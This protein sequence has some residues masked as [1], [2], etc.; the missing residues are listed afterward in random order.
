M[1]KCASVLV[2]GLGSPHGEDCVGWEVVSG[3]AANRKEVDV[4]LLRE[5]TELLENLASR[6][7]LWVIDAC[8]SGAPPGTIHRLTWPDERIGQ[9]R[10]VSSHGVSL[11]AVL[12]LAEKLGRLPDDVTLFLVEIGDA[13]PGSELGANVRRSIAELRHE[14]LAES[15]LCLAR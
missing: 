10:G 1:T 11:E 15:V 6:D 4:L 14:L 13:A 3:L 2:V 5:P 7:R 9:R 8:R 12:Q